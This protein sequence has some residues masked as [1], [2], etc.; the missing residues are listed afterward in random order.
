LR[1]QNHDI[2]AYYNNPNIHPFKEFK[3]RLNTLKDYA[4]AEKLPLIS[5]DK[6]G[7]T[8]FLQ[9][10]VFKEQVRCPICYQMRL[11]KTA[12]YAAEHGYDAFT[13]TLLYSRYQNHELLK[14]SCETLAQ[15]YSLTFIYE[16]FRLGWQQGIDLSIE[17]DMYRQPYCGCIYSEQERYDKSLRRK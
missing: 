5:E 11:Q 1:T 13:T 7:L 17:K 15:Q 3:R 8:E 10:V 16:D 14:K 12:Q 2:T 4:T 6:Y 9:K